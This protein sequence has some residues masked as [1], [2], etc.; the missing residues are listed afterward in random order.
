M[1]VASPL[2]PAGVDAEAVL[3]AMRAV[4]LAMLA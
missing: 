4:A 3:G 1:A 2:D